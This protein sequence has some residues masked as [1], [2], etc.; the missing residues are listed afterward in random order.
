MAA[1]PLLFFSV[2]E[3]VGAL[4]RFYFVQI[5]LRRSNFGLDPCTAKNRLSSLI[6]PS[7]RLFIGRSADLPL[8][9]TTLFTRLRTDYFEDSALDWSWC[10]FCNCQMLLFVINSTYGYLLSG[11]VRDFCIAS[12]SSPMWGQVFFPYCDDRGVD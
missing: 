8:A 10:P 2:S 11:M 1:D 12:P 5:C 6:G 7:L 9:P 4:S 3:A